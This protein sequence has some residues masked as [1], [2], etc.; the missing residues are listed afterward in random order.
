MGIKGLCVDTLKTRMVFIMKHFFNV[1]T[2]ESV[3]TLCHRF[4]IMGE[5]QVPIDQA[6]GRTLARDLIADRDLPEFARATMDGYAVP[7]ASTFGASPGSPAWLTVVGTIAMGEHTDLDLLPGQAARIA[8]GGM[9]PRGADSVAMIEIT[10]AVDD[11]T[12]EVYKS[13]A[14][15]QHVIERGE[16]FEQGRC[17]LKQGR[18]IRPQEAGLLAA[19]GIDPVV[20]Y[21]KPR[22]GIISTGDEIVPVRSAPP[23]GHI[24]DINTYTLQGLI[25]Q[26]GGIPRSYGIVR[27]QADDLLA[28][29]D[30]ALADND[31]LLISGGS[32]VGVRDFTTEVL[33]ALPDSDIL[34]HGIA[35]SP[36]K[37]TLLARVGKKSVWGLPG[38]VV[39]AMIVFDQV[40]RPF[41]LALA[42]RT[43]TE[44]D[45]FDVPAVL[46]RNVSSAQG[47]EEFIRVRLI[48][49]ADHVLAEPVLGKSGTLNTMVLADGLIRIPMNTE[50]LDQGSRVRVQRMA[51]F[52]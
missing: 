49:E 5:E 35:I 45:R 17:I 15:G 7:A 24:R 39:S 27:D 37:P 13:V 3:L 14:P 32:S 40:V 16:D 30:T 48:R 43:D 8:T 22:V 52:F 20:V 19:F 18:L 10:E 6:A 31:M 1:A 2:R 38:H 26:S 4:G 42:G 11:T 34:V 29:C 33:D 25:H 47:R 12:I 44:T 46:S 21:Q 50:G 23:P 9:L 51:P 28:R 36:G 41:I